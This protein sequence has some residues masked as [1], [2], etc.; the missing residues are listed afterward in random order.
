VG[1]ITRGKVGVD[2]MEGGGESGKYHQISQGKIGNFTRFINHSCNPNCQFE[3]FVWMGVER[4]VAVALRTIEAG[5]E[6]TADYS[7]GM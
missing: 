5:A 1:L 2:V 6:V 3:R 7:R 4:I